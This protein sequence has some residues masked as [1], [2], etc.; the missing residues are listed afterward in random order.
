[1]NAP[2][3]AGYRF[4]P[5]IIQRDVWMYLRVTLSYRDGEEFSAERGIIVAY[6]SIRRWVLCFGPAFVLVR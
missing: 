4:P 5:D 6:E 2:S 3:F 1:M